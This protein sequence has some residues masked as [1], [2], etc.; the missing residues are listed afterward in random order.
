MAMTYQKGTVAQGYSFF[1]GYLAVIGSVPRVRCEPSHTFT[2]N[3]NSSM[4][5]VNAAVEAVYA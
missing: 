1:A 3:P 5:N 2:V 4:I